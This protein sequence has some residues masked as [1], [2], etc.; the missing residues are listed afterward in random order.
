ML[1]VLCAF[2]PGLLA[3]LRL[4]TDTHQPVFAVF[5]GLLTLYIL[6]VTY[7][8]VLQSY[9]FRALP[10]CLALL[11]AASLG[12]GVGHA[13]Q[14][15]TPTAGACHSTE[16]KH[17]RG[18][19]LLQVV[20]A[21]EPRINQGQEGIRQSCRVR[22]VAVF[23]G[24]SDSN[25]AP[26]EASRL[27]IYFQGKQPC[28]TG[29]QLYCGL[30]VE[31]PGIS[32][33]PADFPLRR[34]LSSQGIWGTAR[35]SEEQ[36]RY[37]EKKTDV[38]AP[39]GDFKAHCL[40]KLEKAFPDPTVRSILAALSLGDRSA[41]EDDDQAI[42]QTAGTLHVL[43]V[44]G[45][46]V[47]L[48]YGILFG[49]LQWSLSR[50][51][52]QQQL[53]QIL[54]LSLTLSGVWGFALLT[55]A[56]PSTFRAAVL[57]TLFGIGQLAQRRSGGKNAWAATA[58][59][60]LLYNPYWIDSVGFQLSFAAV[61]GILWIYPAIRKVIQW[62][63]LI[64]G[65]LADLVAMSLAAQAGSL[66]PSW[67]YFGIFPTYFLLGNLVGVPVVA[68]WLC[69]CIVL[70]ILPDFSWLEPVWNGLSNAIHIWLHWMDLAG[71]L[72]FSRINLPELQLPLALLIFGT[73]LLILPLWVQRDVKHKIGYA[74]GLVFITVL[75]I[76]IYGKA[77]KPGLPELRVSGS[78]E[79]WLISLCTG[80]TVLPLAGE[81]PEDPPIVLRS[82]L[83]ATAFD[84]IRKIHGTHAIHPGP[85]YQAH[86]VDGLLPVQAGTIQ[87]AWYKERMPFDP[88]NKFLVLVRDGPPPE[89]P[90]GW[91]AQTGK[92]PNGLF[93]LL[94]EVGKR[95]RQRW[96]CWAEKNHAALD[97]LPYRAN[98]VY[99]LDEKTREGQ[100]R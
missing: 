69:S 73:S 20:E 44:S 41:L 85:A 26:P 98:R 99:K 17:W 56:S 61:A 65:K 55:G 21:G 19:L 82:S 4:H 70:F 78:Q 58:F 24:K 45:L 9:A 51:I 25:N 97:V 68:V 30:E 52:P 37:T 59:I 22:V 28:T 36:L 14:R 74:T 64:G 48:L 62:K 39:L 92:G 13:E 93:I 50:I 60:L 71:Q 6:S 2:V 40:F 46:H 84:P 34:Y 16:T 49:V 63:G 87:I 76:P 77:L 8:K 89:E 81:I 94:P 12:Y 38:L 32:V 95:N 47:G 43:A 54:I 96:I 18:I 79:N 7:R 88:Y 86:P 31:Q 10:G 66:A 91:P 83:G 90:V 57:F 80:S 27:L 15:T 72:P 23:S 3:G 11:C 42:F 29:Q 1:F 53:R 100:K 75:C 5:I 67:H 33:H 35:L